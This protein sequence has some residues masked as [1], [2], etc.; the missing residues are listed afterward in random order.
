MDATTF[1]EHLKPVA[2]S[3]ARQKFANLIGAQLT[4]LADDYCEITLP[5]KE[6]LLRPS[7]MFNGGVLGAIADAAAGYAAATHKNGN[8]YLVTAEFK[9]SFLSPAKGEKL[10][11]RSKVIKFGKTLVV[12]DCNIFS[13]TDNKEKLCAVALV[14]LYQLKQ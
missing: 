6:E 10:I 12:A 9:I 7:G 1:P 11:A 14:T 5:A 3:F 8:I 4:A 2:E 13:I